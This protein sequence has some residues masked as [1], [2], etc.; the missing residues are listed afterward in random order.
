MYPLQNCSLYPTVKVIARFFFMSPNSSLTHWLPL[1]IHISD[2]R[3]QLPGPRRFDINNYLLFGV[4]MQEYVCP[5]CGYI[6]DP[7]EG[8]P[9]E[10]IPPNTPFEDLPDEWLCPI[11][12]ASKDV[13]FAK[14]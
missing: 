1:G 4:T 10:G 9:D 5:L 11:C 12:G 3:A 14:S 2:S 13:F 8:D 6:Y 7:V